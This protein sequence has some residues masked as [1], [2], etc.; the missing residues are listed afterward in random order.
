MQ[1]AF[2]GICCSDGYGCDRQHRKGHEVPSV[3]S[4]FRKGDDRVHGSGELPA[5]A[6]AEP[7]AQQC[8]AV[9]IVT[10]DLPP[11]TLKAPV[12]SPT[13]G[14]TFDNSLSVSISCDTDGAAIYYTTDGSEPT[15]DSTAYKRFKIYGKTTVK[16]VAY[17]AEFDLYSEVATAEYALGSCANPTIAPVGGSAVETEGGYV[18]NGSFQK[19]SI[20]K[21]NDEGAIRYTLDGSEPTAE[22]AVYSGTITLDD[23]TTIKAKVFSDRYFDSKTVTVVFTREWGIGDTMGVPDHAFTTSGDGGKAFYRVEDASAPGGNAMRSGDIGNSDKYSTYTR[24]VLSTKV[25]GPGTVSFS[26]KAS[27]EDDAPEYEWDHGEFSVDGVVKVYISGV[28]E[29]KNVSVTVEGS[30]EHVLSWTYLKDDAVFGGEDCIWVAGF[31]WASAEAY[32]HTTNVKVPYEW[33]MKNWPHTIDEYEAYEDAAKAT[34]A[35]GRKVWVC[36]VLGLDPTDPSD[37]FRITRFWMEDGVPKFEF[38]HTTDGSGKSFLSYVKPFGKVQLSDKWRHVPADG[39]PA[40]RFFTVEVLPPGCESSIVDEEELGGV[41]L[42]EN[43]PYW[44]ECNVGATKPEEYGYYFWWGDTVGYKRENGKWV[45]SDGS[46]SNFSFSSGNA[47]TSGKSDSELFSAGYIDLTGNLVPAHDAATVHLGS[48]W[49]MP[50][51]DEIDSLINSCTILWTTKNGVYGQL[52]T[53]KG[54]YADKSIFLPAAGGA[55]DSDFLYAGSE[56]DCWSSSPDSDDSRYAWY[57]SFDS[58]HFGQGCG[59]YRYYGLSVRPVRDSAK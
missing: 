48:S 36:Y 24:T 26:W 10:Y 51:K 19:V 49:R 7:L 8:G 37:D 17:Y 13:S 25:I 41:Q 50:T 56:G 11:L 58:M 47:P 1:A 45:A 22:S 27:C 3:V 9:G 59:Y 29:W 2:D 42:W 35:N 57:L 28:T 33:L 44:A 20:A 43:G 23:T 5:N 16:A 53:G 38:N 31:S 55:F 46:S 54:N 39:N 21:N 40:F 4:I 6:V 52:V 34:A 18:F 15:K 14:M 12:I 30:G 32:T